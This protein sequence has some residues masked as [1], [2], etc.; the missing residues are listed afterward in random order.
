MCTVQHSCSAK[1]CWT[2]EGECSGAGMA[3]LPLIASARTCCP[4]T[5][6]FKA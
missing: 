6:V 2:R 3:R 4:H 5:W 1:A